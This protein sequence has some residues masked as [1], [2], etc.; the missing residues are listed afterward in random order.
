MGASMAGVRSNRWKSDKSWP[1][2][3][4]LILLE[5]LWFVE[6]P[7][8]MGGCMGGWVD[9]LVDWWVDGW[10]YIKSVKIE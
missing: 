2:Q 1:N 3:D 5:D 10:G 7:Q 8:S 6:T 4:N 9:G